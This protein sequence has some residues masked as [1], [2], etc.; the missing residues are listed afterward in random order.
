MKKKLFIHGGSSLI[1]KCFL[2]NC[3]DEYDEFHIFC[4]D[5]VKT[6]LVLNIDSY[7]DKEKKFILYSNDLNN[8][9]KTIED[10]HKL[11]NDLSGVFWVTGFTGDVKKEL[12]DYEKAR[13]NL[14]V[15]L[16]NVVLAITLLLRKMIIDKNSFICVLTSVAGLRGRSNRLY[17]GSAKAGLINFMSGLRQRYN[18]QIKIITVIPGYIS[19]KSL[20]EE[21]SG[22]LVT[23]PEKT[24][25]IISEGIRKNKPVVYVSFIWK[26]IMFAIKLIPERIFK[27][28]N[29]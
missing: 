26:Y 28:L 21:R 7:K 22:F 6:R 16:V 19:T 3:I 8:F 12:D 15:N 13:E 18:N 11:P 10:I 5:D 29:F 20:G 2:D 1:S 4:R 9:T 23:S 25:K 14:N 24:A 17:Y 27:K